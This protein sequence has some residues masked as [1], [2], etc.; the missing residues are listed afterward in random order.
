MACHYIR[1]G[2]ADRL[3]NVVDESNPERNRYLTLQ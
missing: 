3:I 1:S 2:E